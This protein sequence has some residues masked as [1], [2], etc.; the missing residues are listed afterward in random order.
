[1]KTR[2]HYDVIVVGAG[3]AGAAAA[4]RLAARGLSVA[5]LEARERCG[6]RGFARP[7]LGEGDPIDFGGSWITPW[8]EHIRG[9][10]ARHGVELRPRSRIIER[11]WYSDGALHRDGPVSSAHRA[12]H[13]SIIARM[14]AH[15]ALLKA[16]HSTDHHGFTFAGVSL[17]QYL[18]RLDPPQSTRDLVSAWWTVSGNGDKT[19][20]PA[21]EFLHSIGYFDGT[22]DGICAVWVDTLVGGVTL[23]VERMIAA[24]DAELVLSCPVAA[25]THDEAGV[26]VDAADGRAFTARCALLATGLNPLAGIKFAPPLPAEKSDAVAT[27]HLGRAVKIWAKVENVPAGILATGGG[28][29]IEWMLSERALA[30]GTTLLVGFGVAANGWV[31]AM[32]GD[33][34]AAVA[35]FF[36]EARL[37]AVDWHDWNADD[38]SRGAWVASVIGA[39]QAH[40]AQTWARAGSLAFATSDFAAREAGWFEAAII[41]GEDAANEISA[42]LAP[43]KN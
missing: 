37:I 7:F 18:E 28:S 8:Q 5:V 23:L 11:R 32:P 16:G 22:P 30:D 29:G 40:E 21:T 3:L 33:A 4:A 31:P 26:Q 42:S 27:G 9:L 20:V 12:A 10:C 6:G 36:P 2:P 25:L 41:S 1:M 34:E 15:S 19:R 35:R 38:Y 14:A 39:P 24:S 13:E 43:G 17:A